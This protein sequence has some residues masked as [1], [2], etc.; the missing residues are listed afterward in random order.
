MTFLL[1]GIATFTAA[2]VWWVLFTQPSVTRRALQHIPE[3]R[4]EENDTPERY[5]T[6]SRYLLRKG[7]DQVRDIDVYW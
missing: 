7:Y 3:L 2:L 5:L 1:T 6:D 4:F